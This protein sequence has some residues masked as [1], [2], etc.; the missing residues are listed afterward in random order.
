MSSQECGEVQK[1]S[2][3]LNHQ[4][5]EKLNHLDDLV[6]RLEKVRQNI[7]SIAS[8]PTKG[9]PMGD[10]KNISPDMMSFLEIWMDHTQYFEALLERLEK[11]TQEL[12]GF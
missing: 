7:Y 12:E 4:Y 3:S 11:V 1:K 6:V 9:Q 2:T 10:I 5:K 8:V